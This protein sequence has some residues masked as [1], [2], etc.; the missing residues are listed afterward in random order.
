MSP[1]L[2]WAQGRVFL[3]AAHRA[4][5]EQVSRHGRCRGP[6]VARG[7]LSGWRVVW[8]E[9]GGRQRRNVAG[10]RGCME[11]VLGGT[12]REGDVGLKGLQWGVKFHLPRAG[13]GGKAGKWSL[14]EAGRAPA[15]G[16][17]PSLA[18]L[19]TRVRVS[20]PQ[21]PHWRLKWRHTMRASRSPSGP[22][23]PAG[24]RSALLPGSRAFA[25][26]H[27]TEAGVSQEAQDDQT[28]V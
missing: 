17:P 22:A 21:E 24:Q 27:P 10:G 18:P 16:E 1:A 9:A 4:G 2:F 3:Y 13:E 15:G 5:A 6:G 14:A 26:G 12:G 19:G 11:G 28:R 23:G 8:A 20:A 7:Q 25:L